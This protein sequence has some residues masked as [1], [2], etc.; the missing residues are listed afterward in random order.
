M[1]MCVT[2]KTVKMHITDLYQELITVSM[3]GTATIRMSQ[4]LNSNP[5]LADG[6]DIDRPALRLRPMPSILFSRS[7]LKRTQNQMSG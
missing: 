4:A 1:I 2:C 3:L 7:K 6:S 5:L